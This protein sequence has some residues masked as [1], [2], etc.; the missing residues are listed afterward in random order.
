MVGA[1]GVG[2]YFGACLIEAG[3]DV[4][5]LVRPKRLEQI[6]RAGIVVRSPA[7]G[8]IIRP[9]QAVSVE[10]VRG[11]YDVVFLAVKSYHLDA[12]LENVR[13]ID[14]DGR[15][16]I[17]PLLNGVAHFDRLD[18]VFG[19]ERVFGGLCRVSTTVTD[20]GTIMHLNNV[21]DLV[22]GDRGGARGEFSVRLEQEL[23]GA[24]FASRN[25]ENIS[26][27]LWD[28][29]VLLSTLAGATCL[30]RA[31]LGTINRTEGGR[32][33][34]SALLGEATSVAKEEGFETSEDYQRFLLDRFLQPESTLTASMLRDIE[35]G[36]PTESDQIIGHLFRKGTQHGL[37]M[38]MFQLAFSHLQAYEFGRKMSGDR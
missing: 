10:D 15:C 16:V 19:R 27:E 22:F 25:S 38:P 2:G 18:H 35:N 30:M 17:V 6:R 13:R 28:K 29:F 24:K 20:D 37:K 21:Q 12:V 9:A 23:A 1:G 14:E 33:L 5:F 4:T 34:I 32:D 8:D 3:V 31:S 36:N 7:C 26:Q 11:H